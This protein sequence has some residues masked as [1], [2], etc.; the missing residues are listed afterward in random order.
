M[1]MQKQERLLSRHPHVVVATPGEMQHSLE[2]YEVPVAALV[3]DT[4]VA[5]SILMLP[6]RYL[7]CR[8]DTYVAVSI[9]M[10]PCR[11]LCCRVDTYV[12]VWHCGR[13]RARLD[14]LLPTGRLWEFISSGHSFFTSL[15]ALRMVVID[16]ADRM[17]T[18]G[19]FKELQVMCPAPSCFV[20]TVV[21]LFYLC[22]VLSVLSSEC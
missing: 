3:F 7:C 9:L 12:A 20:L 19:H 15:H 14:S 13:C 5:V 16:E 21:R 2:V 1:A 10:L 22:S 18:S 11:Y 17:L 8:V 4:Y 6:C